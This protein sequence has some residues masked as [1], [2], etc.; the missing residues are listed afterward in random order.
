MDSKILDM[1][2]GDSLSDTSP[3]A[4]ETKEKINQW[5]FIKLKS[6]CTAKETINKMKRQPTAWENIFTNDT[7]DRELIIKICKGFMQLNTKNLQTIQ[8]KNWAK[9]LNKHF[10]KEDI[11]TANRH[12]KNSSTSLATR[13]M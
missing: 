7:S 5:D 3:W 6:F 4:R 10:S 1:S 9:D 13:E 2:H 11:Q 12:R 8:F